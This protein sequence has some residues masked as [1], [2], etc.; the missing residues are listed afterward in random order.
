MK[1]KVSACREEIISV[2]GRKVRLFRGGTGAPLLFLHDTFRPTWLPIHEHLAANHE[3]FLPVHPGCAGSED[4]FSD[5]DEVEDLVFHY[6][7][8]CDMLHLDQPAL[9]GASFGGWIAA[10]WAVRD[11]RLSGVVLIDALGLRVTDAPAADILSLDPAGSRQVIFADPNSA[12]A[13]ETIPDNP[14]PEEVIG[15]LLARQ[16]LA[17]FAWQFPD[18]PRLQRYLYRVQAPTLIIWGES[19]RL[20]QLAH[21]KAYHEGI[22]RSELVV[23]PDAGHLPHIETPDACARIVAQFLLKK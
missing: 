19:D 9:V 14:K 13:R 4:G 3:V 22:A 10:E 23:I 11:G 5:L 17:R 16:T 1:M 8:L 12:V 7:D 20:V 18:S 21:G 2:R 15:V 6:R